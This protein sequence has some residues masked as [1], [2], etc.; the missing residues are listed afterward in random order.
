MRYTS[1]LHFFKTAA[2]LAFF[3]LLGSI[4]R[5][6]LTSGTDNNTAQ[7][8]QQDN[9]CAI[10]KN[11]TNELQLFALCNTSAAGL[12]ATRSTDGGVTWIF[13]DAS[14]KTIADGDAG[15]GPTACCDPTLAW[16][17]F[18]N[19]FI[20][21]L[22]SPVDN[23]VTILSTDG[24][25]TFTN[26]AAFGPASVD[27]PTVVAANTTAGVAVWVVWNQ[28]GQMVARGAPVTGLGAVGAFN[29]LQTIPGTAGCSF[30]DIA[31]APNG[32]VVQVCQ[33]P[34]GGEGPSTIIVNTDADGLGAGN[35]GAAVAVTTTNVGGFDF[36][37]AQNSRS[38]DSETGLAFDS[39]SGSPHFGRLYLVYTEETV[40]ENDD[41]NILVR[42][43]DDNGVTWPGGPVTVNDDG[44]NRSQFLP[45]IAVNSDSGNIAICWHD[46]RNSATN[47]AAQ[48]FCAIANRNNFP[49]AFIGGNHLVSD[50]SS[51]SNGV[52]IEFGDYAGLTY[53]KGMAHPIWADISN[54][55]GNNPDTTTGFDAYTDRVAGGAAADEGGLPTPTPTPSKFAVFVDAGA[56]FPHSTFS[57][58]FNT[59]FSLNAGLEYMVAPQFSVEGIFGYHRFPGAFG[60]HLNLFQFSANAKTY[61]NPSPNPVRPF[62]NG[63]IGVYRFGSSSTHFGGNVGGGLLFELT[64]H[65]GLQGSYNFH[66]VNTPGPTTR[67]STLQGGVRFV[68]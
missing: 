14:D 24:G 17:T 51:T 57:T 53:F 35:F 32:A 55:T 65:F 66:I 4:A 3:L 60:G 6:Q 47:T 15:Q 30:G 9:E 54:S 44:T 41:L 37:P 62:L 21:Y 33:A 43:S 67:F 23:I 11:P 26:L 22:D 20:T 45:R 2:C 40:P 36:I 49:S 5:A 10:S 8:T 68:F 13:P 39:K 16:D 38:V 19:L 42:W 7:K 46:A 58:F 1:R 29:A 52:G 28:S 61:L 34:V 64:P 48:T 25:A 12:F 18:G 50:G 27:Q 59:G 56:G 63:G 31:I